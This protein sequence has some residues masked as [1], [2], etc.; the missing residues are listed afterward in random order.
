MKPANF[1]GRRAARKERARER[2]IADLDVAARQHHG[3]SYDKTARAL[4][5]QGF[6]TTEILK[7]PW[8]DDTRAAVVVARLPVKAKRGAAQRRTR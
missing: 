8:S 5:A 4:I 7:R 1:P 3:P 2:M 6:A